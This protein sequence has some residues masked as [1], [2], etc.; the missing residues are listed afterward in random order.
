MKKIK[1]YS[2]FLFSAISCFCKAQEAQTVSMDSLQK[3]QDEMEYETIISI[4]EDQLKYNSNTSKGKILKIYA[5]AYENVNREDKALD[6]LKKA[7]DY[8]KN[9]NNPEELVKINA[10]IYNVLDS[11]KNLNIDKMPYLMEVKKHAE[12]TNSKKWMM[13]YYNH[14]G[15]ANFKANQSDSAK[16]YFFKAKQ[17]A[18]EIDSL[19]ANYK[20][21]INL[22]ALYNVDYNKQDSAIIYYKKALQ[23]YRLDKD[24]GKKL[25]QL[26]ALYNNTGN[27]FRELK[28]YDSALYYYQK[29]EKIDLKQ[30]DKKSKRILFSNMDANFYYMKDWKNA[31]NYLYKY[32]SVNKLIN[33]KEQ[34]ANIN[35]TEEKYDNEKLRADN[36]EIEAKRLQ[37]RNIALVLAGSILL[38]GVIVILTYSNIKRNQKLAHQKQELQ[39]QKLTNQL[40]EQELSSIDAMIEGQEKERLRIANELHDDLGSLMATIKFHFGYLSSQNSDDLYQKTNKLIEQAYEKIRNIAHAKNS[41]VLARDGLFKAIKHLADN[42]SASKKIKISVYEN[43]LDQRLENSVEFTLFRIVQELITNVIKHA[44]AKAIDIHLNEF[45]NHLTIMVEDDGTGFN[46][47]QITKTSPGMGLNNI[48]K[49]VELLNGKMII[50]SQKESGTSIIIEIPFE[51]DKTSLS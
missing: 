25:N 19:R 9:K 10:D 14:K 49:R 13:V 38:G 17:L 29:A 22:G 33:L 42:Y 40:K 30:F 44:R 47:D 6:Y 8:Y 27:A 11:Q 37:N 34:N 41:G 20:I 48:D 31:Y 21:N 32:D 45:D 5:D 7:K 51:N 23:L 18:N 16:N 36:L 2:I 50:E 24:E 1:L 15:V 43:G 4:P 35:E 28:K 26:F 12:K 3:L 46:P 39:M